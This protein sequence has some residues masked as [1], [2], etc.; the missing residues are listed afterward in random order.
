M[1]HEMVLASEPFE[2]IASGQKT[3][4]L[5]LYDEKRQ[6]I[7]IGDRICFYRLD[8]AKQLMTKVVDLHIFDDFTQLYDNLDL[9]K[10]GYTQSNIESAKP[11]DMEV[12]YTPEQLNNYGAIGIELRAE[13]R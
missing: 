9:L 4:E 12:Y 6:A 11:E 5:R 7:A 3:I 8:D 1:K 10:C 2:K 13:E